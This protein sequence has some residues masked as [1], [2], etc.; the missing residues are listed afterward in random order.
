MVS[1]SS[2]VFVLFPGGRNRFIIFVIRDDREV[3]VAVAAVTAVGRFGHFDLLLLLEP[4][5]VG[6]APPP[7]PVAIPPKLKFLV[8]LLLELKLTNVAAVGRLASEWLSWVMAT[9][10]GPLGC[11]RAPEAPRGAA[12]AAG[13][14]L[15]PPPPAHD[16]VVA[17]LGKSYMG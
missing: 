6:P 16:Q 7:G 13:G 17:S 2:T 3:T 12:A 11:Q 8:L 15:P 14:G 4:A 9:G 1:S 10:E 5:T